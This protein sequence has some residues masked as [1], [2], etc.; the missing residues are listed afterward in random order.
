MPVRGRPVLNG[1]SRSAYRASA[2]AAGRADGR[3]GARVGRR[4]RHVERPPAAGRLGRQHRRTDGRRRKARRRRPAR[5]SARTGR[6]VV[7]RSPSRPPRTFVDAGPRSRRYAKCCVAR[8]RDVR[9]RLGIALP[10]LHLFV[11]L[12]SYAARGGGLKKPA[13][14]SGDNPRPSPELRGFGT[15]PTRP[16]R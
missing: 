2:A 12:E 13:V 4:G 7:P 5:G 1:S 15:P 11:L 10:G 9:R 3:R 16:P 14:R 8:P 6:S